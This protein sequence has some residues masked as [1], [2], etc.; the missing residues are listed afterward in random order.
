M[1]VESFRV[2][3]LKGVLDTLK[4]LPPEVVSK[5]GGP[6]KSALRKAALI[7]QRQAVANVQAIIDAPNT[8]GLP[9]ESTG[10]LRDNV[11][12]QRVKPPSGKKGERYMVRV[13]KKRY[14]GSAEWKPRTTAQIGALLEYGTEK[15]QAMPWMRSAF[16]AKRA[17]AIQVFEAELPMA[18]DRIVKRLAKQNGVK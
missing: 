13:R 17:E 4:Q 1:A 9:S 18:I 11:V 5:N 10:L 2:E 14:E 7:I 16:D 15:R 6:V 3:G 8:G 12:A